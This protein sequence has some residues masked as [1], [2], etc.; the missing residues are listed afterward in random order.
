MT[1]LQIIGFAIKAS[2]FLIVFALGLRANFE[3]LTY[4]FRHPGLLLRAVLSMNIIMLAVA[5]ALCEWL[6][7]HPAVRIALV[8]LALS[9]VPPILPG[10][11]MKA[12][13]SIDYTIGLLADTAIVAIVLVPLAI[14]FIGRAF[15]VEMHEPVGKVAT[16]V[17][18]SIMVP[19]VLGMLVHRFAPAAADRIAHPASLIGTLVLVAA[20]IPV[21]VVATPQLVP[22]IGN[23]VLICLV[24]FS[25]VGLAVGHFLGGPE[26]DNRTVL[27]LATS[28]RHPAIPLAIASINFPDEK[29]VVVVVLYHLIVATLVGVPYVKWRKR[30]HAAE[31]V[32]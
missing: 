3:Q 8:T 29:A 25:V 18:A 22:L 9:P 12:G 21:L 17:L 31:S 26:P 2:M 11:Q 20:C 5:I 16:I 7:P 24:V 6:Q 32:A 15:D 1:A 13:G 10:K 27:G 30:A 19:L 4:L 14:E 23:G 28:A